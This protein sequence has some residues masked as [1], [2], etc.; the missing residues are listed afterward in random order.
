LCCS[1]A[2]VSFVDT[3]RSSIKRQ[4]YRPTVGHVEG[5]GVWHSLR[6]TPARCALD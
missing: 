6:H 5:A 2:A 3:Q 1:E 4:L